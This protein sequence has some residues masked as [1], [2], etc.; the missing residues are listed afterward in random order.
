MLEA[1]YQRLY[2][3]NLCVQKDSIIGLM[4]IVQM[5]EIPYNLVESRR[6]GW[7]LNVQDPIVFTAIS[8]MKWAMKAFH[9]KSF[10]G[11][12]LASR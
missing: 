7:V 11:R 8:T 4:H 3:P 5:H 12:D 10:S 9:T 1:I 6:P 2:K